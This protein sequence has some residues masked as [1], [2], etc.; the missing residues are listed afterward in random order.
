MYAEIFVPT[1]LCQPEPGKSCGTCC[2]LYNHRAADEA[3]VFAR[4]ITRT[5]AFRQQADVRDE[6][7][8]RAF[9]E[10]W[11]IA[12]EEKLLDGL[13]VCPFVGF[14]DTL[15]ALDTDAPDL[16]DA[17]TPGDAPRWGRLGCMVHPLQNDGVDGRD[18]GVYDRFIC[19]DYLCAAHTLM[20]RDERWL[21]LNAVHDSYLYGLV[22]TDV[23]FV[24][25]LL[26]GAAR[27]NGMSPPSRTLRRPEALDAARDYMALKRGWPYRAADGIFGQVIPLEGLET[28]RRAGPSASLGLEP[29]ETEPILLCLGTQVTTPE[30][31]SHARALIH[32]RLDAFA[33]AV[34]L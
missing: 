27:R 12:P 32:A 10:A 13:P 20:T 29:D 5:R 28:T 22:I 30:E 4:L 16:S 34:D 26:D 14:L 7:S 24:R 31:L 18:C 11:A 8:L 1:T 9:R 17:P 33:R 6:G 2:G 25:A 21:V 15:D 23:R 19:E 3:E